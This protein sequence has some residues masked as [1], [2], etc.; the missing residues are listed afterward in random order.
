M[1][2]RPSAAAWVQLALVVV[3]FGAAWPVI[4]LGLSA[5]TPVQ[6]AAARASLACLTATVLLAALGRLRWPRGDWAVVLSIGVCQLAAFFALANLGVAAVPPGRSSVLAYTTTLWL[7]P[8]SLA[9]GE[10]V[11]WRRFAGAALGMA[12]VVVLIDPLRF[13]W[14]DRATM[15]GH[16][17]LLLAALLWA[18]AIFHARRHAWVRT[19]LDALPWQMGVATILLW[20]LAF[21]VEP[22]GRVD[23]GR[24]EALVALAYL[25]SLA[26][27]VATWAATSVS[28]ALPPVASS[29]GF[30][31]VPAVGVLASAAIYGEAITWPLLAGAALIAGGIALVATA[32]AAKA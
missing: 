2:S 26:G 24:W 7:V 25:G 31:G 18:V 3:L 32:P 11:G 20:A 4:K 30:L 9:V 23:F 27:P 6:F 5:A 28:R 13:D 16:V 22:D 21:V 8:M 14:S 12:G 15:I 19:P 29:L 17:W 10:P 1:S